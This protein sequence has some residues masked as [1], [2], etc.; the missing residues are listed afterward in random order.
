MTFFDTPLPTQTSRITGGK[1]FLTIAVN[2]CGSLT[3]I[4]DV[5]MVQCSSWLECIT[6][7]K[8]TVSVG[9]IK[10]VV[11][12]SALFIATGAASA[13][14]ATY[15]G[16]DDAAQQLARDYILKAA[17]TICDDAPHG[18]GQSKTEVGAVIDVETAALVKKLLKADIRL[19]GNYENEAHYGVLKE[20]VLEAMKEANQCRIHVF[21]VLVDK[22]LVATPAQQPVVPR[23]VTHGANSPIINGNGTVNINGH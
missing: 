23:Q 1:V 16:S 7:G 17:K 18:G 9:L 12:G 19:S 11:I 8:R 13:A 10:Q 15:P 22:L 20:Q 2:G 4:P 3:E 6:Y 21:D 14:V 5:Q